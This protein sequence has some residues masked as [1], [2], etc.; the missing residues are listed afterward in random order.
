MIGCVWII[1]ASDR[2]LDARQCTDSHQLRRRH[3]FAARHR[4]P[5]VTLIAVV[6]LSVGAITLRRVGTTEIKMGLGL[7]FLVAAYLFCVHWRNPGAHRRLPK[8][9]AV[10]T[11]FAMGTTL[12]F[13]VEWGFPNLI[14]PVAL[15]AYLCSLNCLAIERWEDPGT[16][17]ATRE[18]L[19]SMRTGVQRLTAEGFVLACAAVGLFGVATGGGARALSLGIG[20]SAVLLALI[21]ENR[22]R[23]SPEQLR[24]L[25]DMALAVPAAAAILAA[26][27]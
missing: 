10:G 7:S 16:A 1:Y 6:G 23:F 8:E 20:S 13:W 22:R 24:V 17:A 3:F 11:F 9:L 21:H 26:T 12:P 15:F 18:S 25:A 2:V 19:S 14:L 27:R 4:G 5:L